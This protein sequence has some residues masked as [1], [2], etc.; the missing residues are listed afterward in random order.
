MVVGTPLP[1][2]GL[3]GLSVLD[4]GCGSGR[5]CYLA[6]ALVGPEGKVTG[7][8]MTEELLQV[9]REHADE[10]CTTQLHYPESNLTFQQGYIERLEE[11]MEKA[12]IDLIISNCV[13]NLS[14]DKPAGNLCYLL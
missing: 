6:S 13:I 2:G 1:S 8:D 3:N 11:T 5:D 12:S 4:L 9:A 14:P 7:I 10:Y